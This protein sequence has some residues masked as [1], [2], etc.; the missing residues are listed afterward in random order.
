[1][2]ILQQLALVLLTASFLLRL[3]LLGQPASAW[4]IAF[5][6]PAIYPWLACGVGA[7]AILTQGV[8]WPQQQLDGLLGSSNV[9]KL[10]QDML[11]VLAFTLCAWTALSV[12]ENRM[13]RKS[14]VSQLIQLVLM[15]I[16]LVVSFAL[17]TDRGPT[18]YLFVEHQQGRPAVWLFGS[19]YLLEMIYV[20]FLMLRGIRGRR[21]TPYRWYRIGGY[22]VITA[23]TLELFDLSTSH[24]APIAGLRGIGRALFD[25]VFYPGVVAIVATIVSF[26]VAPWLRERSVRRHLEDVSATIERH[27]LIAPAPCD[28]AVERLADAVTI[29]RNAHVQDPIKLS[30]SELDD[31]NRAEAFL[32]LK[33]G[34]AL[35]QDHERITR[36]NPGQAR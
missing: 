23:C 33:F 5:S 4:R 1:M 18:D 28:R 35:D 6:P 31:L 30:A 2:T 3:R 7:L 34:Y 26:T 17:T 29:V 16:A 11:T 12:D 8:V 27:D 21:A 22:A 20:T 15:E 13:T 25:P 24:F 19:I 36:I 14:T 9:L 10:V 32:Q